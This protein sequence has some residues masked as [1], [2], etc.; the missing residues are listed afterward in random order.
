VPVSAELRSRILDAL[1]DAVTRAVGSF[2]MDPFVF[3]ALGSLADLLAARLDALGLGLCV[4][5]GDLTADRY[6]A[7]P[8][9]AACQ[10]RNP[11][12]QALRRG[13]RLP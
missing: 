2:G 12:L 11:S 6:E 8:Y 1:H 4:D 10:G 9:C 7:V 3:Q 13:G 5:C